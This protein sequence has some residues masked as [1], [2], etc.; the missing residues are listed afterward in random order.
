[1]PETK[2]VFQED[3]WLLAETGKLKNEDKNL[4]KEDKLQPKHNCST[5]VSAYYQ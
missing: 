5:E 3:L 1:M 4:S 2:Y